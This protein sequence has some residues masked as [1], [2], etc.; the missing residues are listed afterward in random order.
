MSIRLDYTNFMADVVSG[1]ISAGDWRDASSAFTNA[2]AGFGRRRQA[3]ELGFLDLPGDQALHRQSTDFASRARGQFDDVV[4]LGIGGSALG[5]IAL[6]TALLKPQWNALTKDERDRAYLEL[7]DHLTEGR[8][9][10]DYELY[11]LDDVAAA[12]ENQS[13]GKSVV[14]LA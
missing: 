3:N 1:G 2:H 9:T 12:W 6:R 4:V 10:L 8:I 5:P 14:L 13:G 11:G 7:L